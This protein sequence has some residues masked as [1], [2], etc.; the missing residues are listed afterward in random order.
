MTPINLDDTAPGAIVTPARILSVIAVLLFLFLLLAPQSRDDGSPMFSSYGAGA[1]GSRALYDVLVRLGFPVRR[2]IR[3]MGSPPESASV[4][5]V[6]RPAQPLTASEQ[7][8]LTAGVSHGAVIVFTA[9]DE[10]LADSLGFGLKGPDG[11]YTLQSASVAGGNPPPA[12]S[13]DPRDLLR[14]PVPI[15]ATVGARSK[16]GNIPFLWLDPPVPAPGSGGVYAPHADS[17]SRPALV[18]GHRYGHGYAIAIAPSQIMMN[19]S[20]HDPRIAIAIVHAIRFACATVASNGPG[21]SSGDA[22]CSSVVFDEYHHGYGEHA[23]MIR[24]ITHALVGTPVGRTTIELIAASLVLL[25]AFAVRP[26][27]PVAA[28]QVSRR[29]PLEHVGA[30]ALAY[31]QVNAYTLGARRLVR[32]LRRRHS[33]GMPM[34]LSDDA[35]L[36]ALRSRLPTTA[37]DVDRV[38]AA[39]APDSPG[40]SYRFAT[41]GEAFANI[42]RAFRK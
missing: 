40:S 39:I 17:S 8:R 31:K 22:R 13:V 20:L 34:S 6:L 36:A 24:A 18:R 25:L 16:T 19:Q 3:P 30:L 12:N 28:P 5:I 10:S 32:G 7:A 35:Y 33:L 15:N 42:E 23:D 37:A 21:D 41:T 29:S 11:F 14:V 2:S 27:A 38:S 1:G 26:L 9:E 4:Y